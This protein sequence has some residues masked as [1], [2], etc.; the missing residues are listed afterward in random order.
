MSTAIII[1][2]CV[3][4]LLA[5]IFD[6]TSARTRIPSVILL[7]LLGWL[8]R[9][10]VDFFSIAVPDL[11]VL[12][13]ILGSVGLILIVLEGSLELE[14][15]RSK[16]SLIRKSL[17]GALAPMI[18]LAFAF[19][20]M[21]YFLGAGSFTN[22]LLNAVPFCVIS[23]AMAIPSARNLSRQNREFITYESSFSDIFGV[24]LFNFLALNETI[25]VESF[26]SFAV[27]LLL[28]LVIS[29]AATIALAFLLN[30]IEHHI[31]FVPIILLVIL[32]YELSKL[33][34]LPGLIF[35]LLFGLFIGNL[36]ELRRFRLISRLNP[37]ELNREVYKFKELIIEFTFLIRALFFL[38][39]GFLMQTAEILNPSTF[40]WALMLVALIYLF[41]SVQ[42]A[43]SK[44]P[45][46]PLL[47]VA[48]RGLITILLFLA[49]ESPR[50]L[51]IVNKSLIV[52][53]ILLTA[54][55]MMFGLLASKS[56]N[57]LS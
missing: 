4:C 53:V 12:L 56:K 26:G 44:L 19:A 40:A 22:S 3:L 5:Y 29:F 46:S 15:K 27:Q 38:L 37:D 18:A 25:S 51:P 33:Y 35:I 39:F 47:Y 57:E 50:A 14:L 45:A 36:D 34:H 11:A 2:L 41:R 30:K 49:I 13:P 21:F 20:A 1:S 24:L 42:L 31:K 16:F 54:F 48:P 55:V 7:L 8:T 32:I 10:G 52:Q 23:S 43:S 28:M 17:L 9:Q 6:F